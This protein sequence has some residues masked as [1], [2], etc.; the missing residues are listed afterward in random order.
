MY[1]KMLTDRQI[2]QI[3]ETSLAIL[4]RIG[5]QVPHDEMLRMFADAGADVDHES[6]RVRIPPELVIRSLE[7]AGKDFV[8]YGRDRSHVAQFGHARRNYNS[9]AGEALWIDGIGQERRYATLEDVVTA[10][11]FADALDTINVVG[12]MS[13]PLETHPVFP[14]WCTGTRIS[15]LCESQIA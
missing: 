12:A 8:I 4:E 10:S 11:R 14:S 2:G 1:A 5:V 7:Q 15:R 9:I 13:D 3:H 6:Q